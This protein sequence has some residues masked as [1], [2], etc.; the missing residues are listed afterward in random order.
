MGIFKSINALQETSAPYGSSRVFVFG[1][2]LILVLPTLIWIAADHSI[3]YGD[4]GGYALMSIG[5]YRNMTS[6]F[7]NWK[8][9]LLNNYK[10][11]MIIWLGEFFVPLAK[12]T[13]SISFSLLLLPLTSLFITLMLT[14]RICRIL[15]NSVA[16]SG[17]CCLI[18]AASPLCNGLCEGFWVD[19]LQLA[20]T[21]W[22]I[23][24]MLKAGSRDFFS[25]LSEFIIA[26]SVAF[27]IKVSSPLYIIGPV[28]G[29]LFVVFGKAPV[30]NFTKKNIFFL[31]ISALFLIA[32]A[33]FYIHNF[34][35]LFGFARYAATSNAFGSDESRGK[36]WIENVSHR[37]FAGPTAKLAILLFAWA[38]VKTIWQRKFEASRGIFFVVIFQI[39]VFTA[40]WIGSSNVDPRYFVPM[41]PYFSILT[42]WCLFAINNKFVTSAIAGIFFVQYIFVTG[43]AFGLIEMDRPYSTIHALNEPD[44][45]IPI[46]ND[47]LP[48]ATRDSSIV[49]DLSPELTAQDFQFELAKH[50]IDRNCPGW[51]KDVIAFLNIHNQV[52]DIGGSNV[53]TVWRKLLDYNPDYYIAWNSRLYPDLAEDEIKRVDG[54][55]AST[56]PIRWVIADKL[57]KSNRF[58][59]VQLAHHPELLVYKRCDK[60]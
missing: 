4:P 11:P 42:G 30:M 50:N 55:N 33:V 8:F 47:L 41:L 51:C 35:A 25:A 45:N 53:D 54:Y 29:F 14:F 37:L 20:I 44:R 18:I 32:A 27:L 6:N 12:L 48:L 43:F 16:I 21:T 58:K 34:T 22:F 39:C 56:V 52:I 40:A 36:L 17:C 57:K 31:F 19:P 24:I 1:F 2:C 5:L 26:L 38:F 10:A 49:F 23:Y 60:P 9:G 15:F 3:W 59:V 28:F 13:G 46:L 7:A